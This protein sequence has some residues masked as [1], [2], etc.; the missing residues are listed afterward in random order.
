MSAVRRRVLVGVGVTLALVA[1]AALWVRQFA[2]GQEPLTKAL[3]ARLEATELWWVNCAKALD[4]AEATM[5]ERAT[6]AFCTN[7]TYPTSAYYIANFRMPREGLAE[8]LKEAFPDCAQIL[9]RTGTESSPGVR[10]ATG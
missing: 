2:P 5:P 9:R 10:T 7:D 3:T 6:D 4:F 8:G 1:A